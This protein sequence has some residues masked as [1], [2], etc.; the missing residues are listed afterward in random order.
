MRGVILICQSFGDGVD[1]KRLDGVPAK[2]VDPMP[3]QDKATPAGEA[4]GGVNTYDDNLL[5]S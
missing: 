5:E 2:W 3:R 4:L 1:E